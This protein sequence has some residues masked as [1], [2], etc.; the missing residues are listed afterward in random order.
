MVPRQAL[1]AL[2]VAAM[3]L[4]AGCGS[5]GSGGTQSPSATDETDRTV[6]GAVPADATIVIVADPVGLATDPTTETVAND[7][8]SDFG[9]SANYS[10][11]REATFRQAN[12]NLSDTFSE[13]GTDANLTVSGI[14]RLAIFSKQPASSISPS[15]A[16]AAYSGVIIQANLTAAEVTSLYEQATAQLP[17]RAQDSLTKTTYNGVPFYRI[18]GSSYPDTVAGQQLPQRQSTAFAVLDSDA[19]LHAAGT[20]QAVRDAIDTY[21]GEAPGVDEDIRPQL[22][23]RTYL[24]VG[25]N[26]TSMD[27]ASVSQDGSL[28]GNATSIT[29]ALQTSEDTVSVEFAVTFDTATAAQ[30]AADQARQNISSD[31]PYETNVSVDGQTAQATV[32]ATA[33]ETADSIEQFIQQLAGTGMTSNRAASS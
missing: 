8:L 29:G 13:L 15:Q 4:L 12:R 26:T 5:L 6:L 24:S 3:L 19:G 20:P 31:T 28:P 7:L 21:L 18:N 1:P 22:T 32:T 14:G 2:A 17:E 33:T 23:D 27:V 25:I 10:E 9:Q 11:I 16:G 30:A